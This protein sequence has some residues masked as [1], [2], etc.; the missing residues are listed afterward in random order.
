MEPQERGKGQPLQE[1]ALLHW[2]RHGEREGR[3]RGSSAERNQIVS[4]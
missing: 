2:E 1:R 3:E 4:W